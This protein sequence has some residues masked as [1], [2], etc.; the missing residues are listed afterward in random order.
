MPART[1]EISLGVMLS[2]VD[3]AI[4]EEPQIISWLSQTYAKMDYMRIA[5]VRKRV[6]AR[7]APEQPEAAP[8]LPDFLARPEE[9]YGNKKLKVS[10]AE[11]IRVERDECN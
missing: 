5:T 8:G 3:L 9:I 7:L 1:L 11:L 6:R 10:G 2:H 4:P